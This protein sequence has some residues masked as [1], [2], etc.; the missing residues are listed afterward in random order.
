MR[1]IKIPYNNPTMRYAGCALTCGNL[2]RASDLVFEKV[3]VEVVIIGR[4]IVKSDQ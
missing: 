4:Q 3:V 2:Q 1:L